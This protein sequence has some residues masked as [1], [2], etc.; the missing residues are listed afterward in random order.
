MT[1]S[2]G[3]AAI[4]GFLYQ[5]LHHL[6]WLATVKLTGTLDGQEMKSGQLVL[7]PRDGGDAQA[8]ARGMYLVEQY[9]TRANNPWSLRDVIE[10][11]RD[12][13][14]SVPS[15]WPEHALYRFVTDGRPGRLEVFRRFLD[16]LNEVETLDDLDD[17]TKRRYTRTLCLSDREFL[18][19]VVTNT[20]TKGAPKTTAEERE[21]VFH[22]L[23]HFEMAF[24]VSSENLARVIE[25]RFTPYVCDLGDEA[26]VRKRLI[27]D[28]MDRLSVGEVTFD[29][30]SLDHLFRKADLSPGR[31][32]KMAEL[33][34]TL[35]KSMRRRSGHLRY[36]RETDVRSAPY[37]APDKPVLLIGGE[38]GAGKSWQMARLMEERAEAGD[39]VVFIRGADNAED[40]LK[41]AAREIWQ[42][43]LGETSDKTLQAISNF[44]REEA[45]QP[46]HGFL[47]AVDDIQNVDVVRGLV[48]QDWA[49][50]RFRLA[51]TVPNGL[52][53]KLDSMD[54]QEVHFHHVDEFS[55]DE[56]D[57]LLKMFGH[58]WSDLPED[59]KRL[60]RKPVLAG[61]FLA[62]PASSFQKAPQS[63]YEIFQAFWKRIEVSCN[64]GD[65]GI[66]EA[67]ATLVLE[68]QPY[69]VPRKDWAKIGLNNHGPEA[70]QAA[71]WLSCLE[72]G[73]VEFAHDRLLNWAVAQSLARRFQRRELSVDELAACI[74]GESDEAGAETLGRFGYVP[75]DM[76]WLL[77]A[78]DG[79]EAALGQL[80]EKME[81]RR[82]FGANGRYLY[83]KLLPTL[84]RRAIPI[85]LHRLRAIST[86]STSDHRVGLIGDAFATLARQESVEIGASIGPLLQSRVWDQQSVAVKALAVT[87]ALEHL[88]RLWEIH[89]ERL[90]AREHNA[91][92]RLARGH[93]ATFSA[94]R[95]GVGQHPDWLRDR[96][97]K[98]DPAKERISELGYLLSGLD[99]PGAASIWWDVRDVLT[100]KIGQTAPRSLL[101]CIARFVDHERK[102]F[103][104]EHL[105]Y[106]G[107]MVSAV[108]M[109]ALAVLDPEQAISRISVVDD[110]QEFFRNDWLPLLLRA[111]PELTRLR[112]RELAISDWRGQ[113]TMEKF[114]EER[115]ADLDGETLE[116]VLRTRGR[117][118]RDQIHDVTT[119][120]I[121]WPY[122]PLRFLTR[123]CSPAILRR[124]QEEAGGELEAAITELGCS[125]L[126]D[127]TRVQDDIR[128][129]ARRMLVLC[130]G[131][132]I[133]TLINRELES[134]HF[135]V[136][137]G[138]LNSAW[139]GG[140]H[141]TVQLLAE[142]ARRPV[143][144]DSAGKPEGDTWQEFYEA[145]IGLAALGADEI[146]V[147]IFSKQDF[148][149]VPLPLADFRA[150]RGPMS[151]SLTETAVRA[152]RNPETSEE[153]L[154]CALVIAWLSGDVE[155]IPDVRAV[156]GR[157]HPGSRC[158]LHACTALRA[159]GDESDDL[160]RVAE[161]LA[162]TKEYR[163]QGLEALIG[164]GVR[165]VQG[166]RRWLKGGGDKEGIGHREAVI[167]ALYVSPEGRKD[168]IEA[169]VELCRSGAWLRMPY[170]VAGESRDQ[171]VRERILEEAFSA[172]SVVVQ[173]PLHAMRGL[174]KF[175]TNR[176]VEAIELGLSNH[177]KIERELCRLLVQVAP[178]TAAERLIKAATTLERDSLSE[179]VGQALRRAETKSVVEVVVQRLDGSDR[180]RKVVCEISG[181]L[182]VPEIAE[183]LERVADRESALAVRRAALDGLYR[184]REEM[185]IG[186]L[187]SAFQ[188]ERRAARRWS[189]FLAILETADPH[190][191]SDREDRLWLGHILTKDVPYAFEHYAGRV[192]KR[193][194]QKRS[195]RPEVDGSSSRKIDS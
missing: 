106:S 180:E 1:Q 148:V 77:S 165:G 59:L 71:G 54:R 68:G 169:A 158:A 96:I 39:V 186:E 33:P 93:E 176:T 34:Q 135:W 56:L 37:P 69:P 175:D 166:L 150:H 48:R 182:P 168:A 22:L 17:E 86:N 146:L 159:L 82:G 116:L 88:D 90:D 83:T 40:V 78:D 75:M 124:L 109:M 119:K 194:M 123:L 4:N 130:G 11:L 66:V 162:F 61:L 121:R 21:L 53:D 98:A 127:N 41:G 136:R 177:P 44:F 67:L 142:I 125:R 138:G 80:V 105:S 118:L 128:E 14:R 8:H 141:D 156:L 29:S 115:P 6:N 131:T 20:R 5:I 45:F 111:D 49:C 145:T 85:L 89:Q 171:A 104:V 164:L 172:G 35:A 24:E 26:G 132:G 2:G 18:D 32:R 36:Q 42:V 193:P 92:R 157:V 38:S 140:D 161:S 102:D 76:L 27:G 19:H 155:L 120:D 25:A 94:L 126:H 129:A 72:L 133:S 184:H 189:Y 74:L 170:E 173:A 181:W 113:R 188:A 65:K 112:L 47:I 110:E 122:Y 153:A 58:R 50:L 60:L 28:L 174:A 12:L 117:Q 152:L 183:A 154:L 9:K 191:L 46:Q 31:L 167:R 95:T 70:L 13:R 3:S 143:P 15:W 192:L 62:L 195:W 137:H 51:M 114:F 190:L 64:A 57:A 134:E 160:A 149:D 178:E 7:E 107:E 151:K 16:H 79:N 108:A 187:F 91:D 10:V 84:G 101:H 100:E 30:D 73:E 43:G 87:P 179:A 139:I 23:R 99:V 185:A 52:V 97:S 63:E 147:E 103:V 163:W 81:N 144:R 55:I